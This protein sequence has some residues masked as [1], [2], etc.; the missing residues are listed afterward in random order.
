[1][2]DVKVMTAN[3]PA[4]TLPYGRLAVSAGFLYFGN[5]SN[6]PVKVSND[7]HTH[8]YAP[9]DHGSTQTTYGLGTT[10][11]Y[12]HVKTIDALTQSSHANGTALSAYQG[13]LLDQNKGPKYAV[14]TAVSASRNLAVGDVN[15]VL[16]VSGTYTLTIPANVFTAGSQITIIN[17]GTGT[18]TIACGTTSV[19]INGVSA[20]KAIT[21]QYKACTLICYSANA[22]YEVGI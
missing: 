16:F 6:A 18:V 12:G 3:S 21:A 13:Y 9:T 17:T 20:S 14:I 15:A 22:W 11:N 19:Y 5:A 1:M 4:A 8:A 7:G 2:G 10:A